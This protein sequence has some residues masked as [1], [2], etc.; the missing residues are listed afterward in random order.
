MNITIVE[1]PS[2]L[3]NKAEIDKA[4]GKAREAGILMFGPAVETDHGTVQM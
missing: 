2:D 4:I 1:T 3:D